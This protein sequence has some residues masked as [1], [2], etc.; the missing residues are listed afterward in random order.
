[1]SWWGHGVQHHFKKAVKQIGL[2][3]LWFHDLRHTG[4]TNLRRAGVDLLTIKKISGHKSF[5][6]FERYNTWKQHDL[7][8]AG[9]QLQKYLAVTLPSE[10]NTLITQ[11]S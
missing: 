6:S 2:P 10:S 3:H 11:A 9:Q 7:R 8:Q 1:L 5:E 4:V